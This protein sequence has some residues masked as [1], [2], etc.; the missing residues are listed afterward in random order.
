MQRTRHV[1]WTFGSLVAG[2]AILLV[3]SGCGKEEEVTKEPALRPVRTVVLAEAVQGRRRTFP[4]R[5]EAVHW[6]D[7]AFRVDGPLV[8]FPVVEGQQVKKGELLA[9]IDPRDYKVQLASITSALNE[10]RANLRAMRVARPEDIRKFEA[11]LAAAKADLLNAEADYQRFRLL[12]LSDNA[13]KADLDERRAA[14]DIA[15]ASV[16]SAE[17]Q[18]RIGRRGERKED[19]D[20]Q[21]ARIQGLQAERRDALNAF[22]DT[23]LRAQFDGIV[24]TRYVKNNTNV[25]AKQPILLLQDTSEI[26]IKI[27]VPESVMATSPADVQ[28]LASFANYPGREFPATLREFSTEANPQTQTYEVT[29]IMPQPKDVRVLPG[30]TAQVTVVFL[31]DGAGAPRAF[32]IPVAAVA[33]DEQGQSYAWVVDPEHWTVHKRPVKVGEIAKG[34]HIEVLEGLKAGERI[35]AAGAKWLIEGQKVR[36][37]VKTGG[38]LS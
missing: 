19:I 32:R 22:N 9:Q 12:Y 36:E 38:Q 1:L 23:S 15:Q 5:A 2:I 27:D 3:L 8:A 24:A 6:A 26:K 30:M 20:A 16:K 28:V 7:L 21:E 14:R 11:A 10:A 33:A 4:G 37:M 31:A 18:L 17:Q 13:S 29:L 25:K 34:G 35:V